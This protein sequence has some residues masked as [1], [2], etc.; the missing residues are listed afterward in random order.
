MFPTTWRGYSVDTPNWGL[1]PTY[2]P[3]RNLFWHQWESD[4][5]GP[6]FQGNDPYHLLLAFD[7]DTWEVVYGT[8]LGY[9]GPEVDTAPYFDDPLNDFVSPYDFGFAGPTTNAPGG[10]VYIT[11]WVDMWNDA[12]STELTF[13]FVQWID[14]GDCTGT[15]PVVAR[16]RAIINIIMRRR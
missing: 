7:P 6:K 10:K 16:R 11:G 5:T 3:V 12:E 15:T 1:A 4:G 14:I 13:P 8:V 9:L 2:D